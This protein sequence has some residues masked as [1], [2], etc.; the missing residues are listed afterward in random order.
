M[1]EHL[2]LKLQGKDGIRLN[3]GLMS[4]ANGFMMVMKEYLSLRLSDS[5]LF[6]KYFD[7]R[8]V[9]KGIL[10]TAY[11]YIYE[12]WRIYD[13]PWNSLVTWVVAAILTDLGYYWVHRAAHGEFFF[14]LLYSNC[15]IFCFLNTKWSHSK[16]L[17]YVSTFFH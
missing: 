17:E 16:S 5:R 11:F 9:L 6:W 2:I 13:L 10:L 1:M 3:D 7:S 15:P 8:M 12:N 14:W 4:I